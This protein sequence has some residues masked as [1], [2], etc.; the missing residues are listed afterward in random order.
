MNYSRQ[1]L[2]A[3]GEP[4]GDSATRKVGGKIIYGGGGGAPAQQTITQSNIPDWLR[5]QV[6]TVLGGA[7]QQMF[8]TKPTT[9]QGA[10]IYDEYGQIT[11]YK[12]GTTTYEVTGVKPFQAFGA[13]GA[14][15]SPEAMQAAQSAV[16][17]FTP[18]QQ[19]AFQGAAGLQ[20]P[21]QFGTATG[22]SE[23][24]GLGGLSA[25]GMATG[26]AGQ[27]AG[28][29][30][31]YAQQATSPAAMQAY[32]SPYMQNVVD[33]QQQQAQRQAD[34]A[35]QA[36]Q[37]QFAKMGAFGGSAQAI[38]GQQAAADLLRQKQAIQATGSQNA[39]QQAQQAQQFGAGLGLQGL[40]G[41]QQ[42]LSNV[43]GGYGLMG[44]M[45]GQLGNLG[46]QQ[47]AAQQGI[48]GTQAQMGGTQ[49][50]QQQNIIN[51]A[52]QNY[53]Q[54][55]QY[56]LQQFN[57]YNALL[58][59]YAV[60]GQTATTYQA[61]PSLASQAIGL[62]GA[63]YMANKAGLFKEGGEVKMATGGIASINRKV[64]DDPYEFSPQQLKQAIQ[65]KTLSDLIGVPALASVEQARQQAQGMQAM[66]QPQ[67]PPIAEQVMAAADQPQG[68]PGLQSNLPV[69]MAGGGI[70]AFTDNPDQPVNV[71]M[72]A[73]PIGRTLDSG[74]RSIIAAGAEA[75]PG[76]ELR[77][78]ANKLRQKLA[79]Q[80]GP[81]GAIPG[82]FMRQTDAER[83]AAK[84]ITSLLPRMSYPQ[85][86]ALDKQGV[87]ALPDLKA[88]I[89]D[90]TGRALEQAGS[91][92]RGDAGSVYRGITQAPT[93]DVPAAAAGP[94]KSGL[95]ALIN[96]FAPDFSGLTDAATNMPQVGV[97]KVP[98]TKPETVAAPAI[99][100]YAGMVTTPS[101]EDIEKK[102]KEKKE[103]LAAEQAPLLEG[104]EARLSKR[105]ERL[106]AEEEKSPYL[107]AMK[108]FLRT[109]QQR[110]PLG[111]AIAAGGEEALNEYARSEAANKAARDKM[112]DARDAYEAM[113][114]NLASGNRTE[115]RANVMQ[116]QSLMTEAQRN[117]LVAAQAEDTAKMHIYDVRQRSAEFNASQ[118]NQ[119]NL[120]MA[121]IGMQTAHYNQANQ[122][123]L[124][125]I[126]MHAQQIAATYGLGAAKLY[127]LEQHAQLGLENA[128]VRLAEVNRKVLKDFQ[129]DV[130][131]QYRKELK[132]LPPQEAQLRA[133]RLWQEYRTR[134]RSDMLEKEGNSSSGL[135]A[136][137]VEELLKD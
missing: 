103:A 3:L 18:L 68:I 102:V 132:A 111:S 12:P 28:A 108:G 48:L 135:G 50:Q 128:K 57:A 137:T 21:G 15:T 131:P 117:K 104:R 125:Q 109:A 1:Q 43:L 96:K 118:A 40:A 51:Q 76:Y 47:L 80:Y 112:E 10:P 46:A 44:Q 95:D 93:P 66:Q 101:E 123:A 84:D 6:E 75:R 27:Q 134:A 115:A 83:Q 24:A 54:S 98:F 5:P 45:G 72:P 78:A 39:F 79:A 119:Y 30:A 38:A 136:K 86:L 133:D 11:G 88:S 2:Y 70:V 105:E 107:A 114:L 9:T 77:D 110:G 99:R 122:V 74:I 127:T 124:M 63:A 49:Q 85:L 121:N 60:P 126:G 89:T 69:Q 19:Q 22:L 26:L 33:V 90:P 17:G 41:A 16:A 64:L 13:Q 25:A 35:Q 73:T 55:Q 32:M 4:L 113:K 92:Q 36:Q 61:A 130:L 14:G 56:P 94:A 67:Q 53:A 8:Q 71:N 62:G 116:M 129:T 82:L 20:M 87:A 81:Q 31:Q 120:T 58:R 100:D 106:K 97:P 34:I 23:Q 52:I 37:A 91:I 42:G 7:M 59:G 29:G 65:N